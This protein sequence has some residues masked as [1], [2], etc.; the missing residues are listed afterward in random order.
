MNILGIATGRAVRA[1]AALEP[2]ASQEGS[3]SSRSALARGSLLSQAG[4]YDAGPAE[5]RWR[6]QERVMKYLA[7]A[8][9]QP[10]N[11]S[12]LQQR[13]IHQASIQQKGN[14]PPR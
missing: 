7:R 5:D 4:Y 9:A 2:G 14:K 12:L 8:Q 3:P 11:G 1:G 13:A 10:L 6:S